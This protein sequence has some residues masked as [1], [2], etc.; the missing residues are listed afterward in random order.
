[1]PDPYAAKGW[2]RAIAGERRTELDQFVSRLVDLGAQ[3]DEVQLVRDSWDDLDPDDST[4]PEAFTAARRAEL[5]RMPDDQL[6]GLL[7]ASREEHELG[8]TT[9]EEAEAHRQMAE[10]RQA[11]R[12]AAERIAGN[13]DSVLAWVADDPVRAEAVLELEEGPDGAA[14]KTLVGPLRDLLDQEAA[15]DATAAAAGPDAGA[16]PEVPPDAPE[17]ATGD[18]GGQSSDGS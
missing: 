3:P 12:E 4:D 15:T 10:Y 2:P 18:Q 1:V 11:Y 5:V 6:R 7:S 17:A 16:G 9:E 8:T 14:R 13:V